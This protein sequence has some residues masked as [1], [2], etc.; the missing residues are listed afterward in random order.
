MA[1]RGRRFH[2]CS[3]FPIAE[4]L[5]THFEEVKAEYLEGG[6]EELMEASSAAAPGQRTA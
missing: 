3:K 1:A 4:Y 5:R 2:D 6:A